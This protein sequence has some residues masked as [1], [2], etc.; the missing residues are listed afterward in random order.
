MISSSWQHVTEECVEAGWSE[1]DIA[2]L[3]DLVAVVNSLED[4][5]MWRPKLKSRK[6][7]VVD[8]LVSMAI[9]HS[10][11]NCDAKIARS[12]FGKG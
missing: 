4:L 3:E 10:L 11:L 2:N 12:W 1:V 6:M 8:E 7:L 5:K 9:R